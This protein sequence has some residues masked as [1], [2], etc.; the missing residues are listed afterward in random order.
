MVESKNWWFISRN[1]II[2]WVLRKKIDPFDQLLEVG[3]GTG[4][5]LQAI[6]KAF[7]RAVLQGSDYYD[8]GLVH[9]RKRVPSANF[10]Q[11]DARKMDKQEHYDVIGAFDVIEHINEDGLVLSNLSRALK[12]GTFVLHAD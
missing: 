4:F 6:R 5:V 8:V 11:L 1:N 12:D 2:L 7:P 10:T 9:A 3:C